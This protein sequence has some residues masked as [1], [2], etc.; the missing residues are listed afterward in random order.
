M[1]KPTV[2]QLRTL[3]GNPDAYAVQHENGSWS[4]MEEEWKWA[5]EGSPLWDHIQKV[6]T[7]GT[8]VLHG[9]QA[10]TLVFDL[11]EGGE[12][13]AQAEGIRD[14]LVRLGV[15]PRSIGI[16]FSGQKGH[17]VWVVL[18]DY[19][20]AKDLR[21]LG[22]LVLGITGLQCEVFPKQDAAKKL[23]NLVKL[24]GGIHQVSKKENNFVDQVPRPMS[25]QVLSRILRDLPP[26]PDKPKNHYEGDDSVVPCLTHIAEGTG[27]G[28]RNISLYHYAVLLRGSKRVTDEGVDLLVRAAAAK[29]DPPYEGEELDALLESS[30]E[31][32]PLCDSLPESVRCPIDRCVRQARDKGLQVRPGQLR[33][34]ATGDPVVVEVRDRKG[35]L[36]TLA[37]PDIKSG[38]KVAVK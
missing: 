5:E 4:P 19:V 16:E 15:P 26:E 33:G 13:L 25:V 20:L 6:D 9:D 31:G 35:G 24:P 8:Y 2:R 3:V 30:K 18:A 17:H 34:C 14:E 1:V 36:V 7:I 37:H 27:Y 11:D 32:G 28:G 12:T 10:K 22:R 29:C 38:G 21:R 23:G